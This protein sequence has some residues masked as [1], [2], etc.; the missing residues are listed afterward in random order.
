[1]S[2]KQARVSSYAQAIFQIMVERWQSA[3]NQVADTLKS[4]AVVTADAKNLVAA[5]ERGLPKDL[6]VEVANFVKLLAQEGD[7]DLLPQVSAALTQIG[8][9]RGGPIKAEIV[10]AAELSDQE[11]A[12][13]RKMLVTQHGD[14]LVFAFRVDPTLLGGLRVRVGDTLTDTSVATRLARLRESLATVVR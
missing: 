7:L 2:D 11:Q 1:M 12:D 4:D 8:S 9:G 6:P 5:V 10:S 3:L 14:G 13:L